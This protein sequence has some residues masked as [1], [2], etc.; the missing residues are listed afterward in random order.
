MALVPPPPPAAQTLP[1][2]RRSGCFGCGCGGCLLVV[3]LIALLLGGA[4]WWFFVI[5]ASA[6]VNAPA[7][8]V[9]INQPITVDGNPGLAGQSLNAGST[10]STGTGG[11]GSIV[12]PDGS[13]MRLAPNT[14]VQVN[15]VQLQK[16]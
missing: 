14:S 2:P 13:T 3:V 15:S 4:G 5:Q 9:V 16:T 1:Q 6:A 8:L 10:V 12:F 7:S 11:H